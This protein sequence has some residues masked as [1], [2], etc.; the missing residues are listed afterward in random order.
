MRKVKS[1]GTTPSK[2]SHDD[3]ELKL[4]DQVTKFLDLNHKITFFLITAAVGTIGFSL[5]F[6]ASNK[7]L[8]ASNK[9]HVVLVILA[10]V[11]ALLSAGLSLFALNSDIK[12]FRLHLRYRHQRRVFS[13][14]T[15]KEK[16]E[17]NKVIARAGRARKLSIWFLVSSISLQLFII[18][19][20]FTQKGEISMNHYGE[21]STEV[22][23]TEFAFDI[24]FINKE[25]GQRITMH[26]PRVG[27]MKDPSKGPTMQEVRAIADEIAHV[28]RGKLE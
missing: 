19:F 28:L 5:N 17:W 8:I 25:T 21:D 24:A 11:L 10:S 18:I 14:L 16:K 13:N 23:A 6:L 7:L 9:S 22:T 2:N 12:S 4:D 1:T 20:L 3:Y 15:E 26:I 27:V